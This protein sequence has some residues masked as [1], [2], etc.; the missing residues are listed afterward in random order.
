MK[1]LFVSFLVI[2]LVQSIRGAEFAPEKKRRLNKT[3]FSLKRTFVN[4]EYFIVD[5]VNENPYIRHW[6]PVSPDSKFVWFKSTVF[7]VSTDFL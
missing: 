4:L 2:D 6:N 7:F 1:L 5:Q 3:T